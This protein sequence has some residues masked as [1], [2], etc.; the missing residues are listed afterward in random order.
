MINVK[1]FYD[2]LL[3]NKIEFFT[4]VPDSLLKSLCAYIANNTAKKDHIIAANEGNALSIGVGYYLSSKKIPLIYMQN[5]GLGNAINPLVSIADEDVYSIP[6]ILLVGW[7]GEQGYADEPQHKKQG[8][9]TEDLLKTIGVPYW[10]LSSSTADEDMENIVNNACVKAYREQKP[11][12]IIVKKNTFTDYALNIIDKGEGQVNREEAI[13]SI[14]KKTPNNSIVVSTTGVTS[15]ELF[16]VRKS[17]G[18][19]H[20]RDFL[21]VGGM[22]HVSQIALGIAL[23][24]RDRLVVCMDGDGSFLMHM[25]SVAINSNVGCHNF[26]HIVFNNCS[27]ES[28]GGQPTVASEVDMPKIASAA[29]YKWVGSVSDMDGFNSILD[30]FIAIKGPA[31]LEV[32]TMKG[33]RPGLGRPTIAMTKSKEMFMDYLK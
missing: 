33:Y 32:K 27:H 23:N 14:I 6:M 25:G 17:E 8:K 4:G 10:I 21:C 16:E 11:C 30:D 5:S 24:K 20:E 19:R 28:V 18:G 29:G 26:K 13:K 22:G 7:R 1:L 2:C 15:R 9:I 12:A 3:H 31:F